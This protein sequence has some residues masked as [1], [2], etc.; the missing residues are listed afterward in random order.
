M[1]LKR[2]DT[3]V[4]SLPVE[5][6]RDIAK[7]RL[8]HAI[9]T[10]LYGSI[11]F[12]AMWVILNAAINM[13]Y[14]PW[15]V[16]VA[17]P[18][19]IGFAPLFLGN[20]FYSVTTMNLA[21]PAAYLEAGLEKLLDRD[22]ND[23]GQTGDVV[24]P[25]PEIRTETR[26]VPVAA[27]VKTTEGY[28]SQDLREFIER[29][30]SVGMSRRMWNGYVFKSGRPCTREVYTGMIAILVEKARA[31]EGRGQGTDGHFVKDKDQVLGELGLGEPVQDGLL[32]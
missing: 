15:A 13:D 12:V 25:P 32:D 14:L 24:T 21:K 30:Y 5:S 23:S 11:A 9:M 2:M 31:V 1:P 8:V 3:P 18:A 26:I 16:Y 6:H 10:T 27:H 19:V 4:T 22:L 20:V 17:I 28:P 7:S 29:I